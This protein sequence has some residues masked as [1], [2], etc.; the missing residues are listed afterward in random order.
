MIGVFVMTEGP[1]LIKI[2]SLK[3]DPLMTV[4]LFIFGDV[5]KQEK[6]KC[7][8]TMGVVVQELIDDHLHMLIIFLKEG[9]VMTEGLELIGV[10]N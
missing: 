8:R 2:I 10:K 1:L 7:H 6:N 4:G 9:L 3:E 5:T